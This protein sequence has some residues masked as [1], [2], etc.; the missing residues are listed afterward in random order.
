MWDSNKTITVSSLFLQYT[1]FVPL[2]FD[3]GL[4]E[5][6]VYIAI[7]FLNNNRIKIAECFDDN[8]K[9]TNYSKNKKHL[10]KMFWNNIVF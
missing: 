10:R 1:V 8:G 5:N 9:W 6:C 3:E 4:I 2:S 7:I